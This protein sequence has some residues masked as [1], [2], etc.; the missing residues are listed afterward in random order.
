MEV[1]ELTL[2]LLRRY[3]LILVAAIVVPVGLAA[4]YVT[5]QPSTYTA[6]T[7]I[8]ASAQTPRAQA[9][10]AALASQVNAIATSRD[11]VAKALTGAGI[12][13]DPDA[14]AASVTVTGLGSSALVD[15]AYTDRSAAMAQQVTSALATAVVEQ[16]DAIAEGGL[17]GVIQ[18]LDNQLTD[19]AT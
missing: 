15:L 9:E 6:H 14:V 12:A 10:A 13:R 1:D 19:L 16:L 17:P 8:I 3:W 4:A 5:Y 11:L 7:R 2:R 18:N